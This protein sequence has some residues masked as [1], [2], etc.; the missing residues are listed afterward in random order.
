M[1]LKPQIWSFSSYAVARAA[2]GLRLAV[3]KAHLSP[4]NSM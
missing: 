1:T 3:R 4:K 2:L